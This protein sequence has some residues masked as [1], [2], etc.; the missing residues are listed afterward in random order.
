[1]NPPHKNTGN[2]RVLVRVRPPLPQEHTR[3]L[4]FKFVDSGLGVGSHG[5]GL[6]RALEV[7]DPSSEVRVGV[8]VVWYN[9]YT[10][11][12]WRGKARQGKARQGKAKKKPDI[13]EDNQ[14]TS[15][16]KY[17]FIRI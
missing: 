1:L 5:E 6:C 15:H 12:V 11:G 14:H 16:E 10:C 7:A 9:I 8:V 2:I 4:P 17:P 3:K 13:L